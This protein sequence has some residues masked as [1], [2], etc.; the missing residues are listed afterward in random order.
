MRDH[1]IINS[2]SL[3][4]LAKERMQH[5]RD[6]GWD[7][8]QETVRSFCTKN[9]IKIPLSDARYGNRGRS[10]RFYA[11]QTID[12]HYRREVLVSLLLFCKSLIV[13]FMRLIWSLFIA[14]RL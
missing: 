13:A 10:H 11:N 1:D 7:G 9:G 3:V 2:M 14:C 6:H 8:S 12:D 4:D 5:M